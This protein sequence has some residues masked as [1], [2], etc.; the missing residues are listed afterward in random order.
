MATVTRTR[1]RILYL[2][3]VCVWVDE[4]VA[5]YH[6]VMDDDALVISKA[7]DAME[8]QWRKNQG[9]PWG[10]QKDVMGHSGLHQPGCGPSL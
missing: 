7:T 8:S 5:A 1:L 3:R 4:D 2:P 9:L 6:R 10:A